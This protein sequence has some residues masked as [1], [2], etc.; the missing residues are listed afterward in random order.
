MHNL[1]KNT[2]A[3]PQPQ[4]SR[5]DKLKTLILADWPAF[6]WSEQTRNKIQLALM[7]MLQEEFEIH[8]WQDGQLAKLTSN[9]LD[10]FDD[11]DFRSK[12]TPAYIPNGNQ[13]AGFNF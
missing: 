5:D 8:A 7:E 13:N 3:W 2:P 4:A 12:M 9:T 1:I 11:K 6:N 10:Y